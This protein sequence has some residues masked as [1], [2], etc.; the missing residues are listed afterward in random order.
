[1][2]NAKFCD[3]QTNQ[4]AIAKN[5]PDVHFQ[6]KK[7]VKLL[8]FARWFGALCFLLFCGCQTLNS[9]TPHRQSE[10]GERADRAIETWGEPA[11]NILNMF[12][13]VR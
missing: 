7:K 2:L 4:K 3:G 11:F 9:G 12:S 13:W 5:R 1:V 10:I 6:R 8:N